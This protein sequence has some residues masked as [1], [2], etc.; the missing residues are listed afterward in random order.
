M[1]GTAV[2]GSPIRNGMNSPCGT[3]STRG[4]QA[5]HLCF[6]LGDPAPQQIRIEAMVQGYRRDRNTRLHALLHCLGLELGA[7]PTSAPYWRALFDSVH[8]ST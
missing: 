2:V 6:L 7:M 1:S 4:P 5:R 3:S 8:V